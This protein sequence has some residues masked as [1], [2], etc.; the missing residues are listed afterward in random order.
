MINNTN[1]RGLNS[2]N[3]RLKIGNITSD[4]VL[5]PPGLCI[6]STAAQCY[7]HQ[8]FDVGQSAPGAQRSTH[9]AERSVGGAGT[10]QSRKLM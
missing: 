3:R 10:S 9:Y 8:P 6:L 4:P 5:S 2:D 7:T 1:P